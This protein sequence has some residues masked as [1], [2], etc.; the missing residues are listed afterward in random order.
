VQK[1]NILEDENRAM[2]EANK[3]RCY[4]QAIH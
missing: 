3:V 2:Y 1:K 4:D